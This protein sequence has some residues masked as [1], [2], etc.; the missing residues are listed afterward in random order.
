MRLCSTRGGA[1]Q[2]VQTFQLSPLR[3]GELLAPTRLMSDWLEAIDH[4]PGNP[5]DVRKLGTSVLVVM[6]IRDVGHPWPAIN[7]SGVPG[8]CW[9]TIYKDPHDTP[10]HYYA[11]AGLEK[12]ARPG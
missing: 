12:P 4:K 10:E 1:G 11:R 3:S 8:R 2:F 7:C 9:F 5:P 6:P